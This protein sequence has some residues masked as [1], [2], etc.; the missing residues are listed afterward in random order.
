[1]TRLI[2]AMHTTDLF[3]TPEDLAPTPI[4]LP[5]GTHYL[6]GF[7]CQYAAELNAAIQHIA[8]YSPFRQVMTPSGKKCP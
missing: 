6:K 3:T 1:M 5:A 7:A 4:E 8:T 2:H